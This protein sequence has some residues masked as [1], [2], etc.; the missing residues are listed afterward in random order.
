MVFFWY[1]KWICFL[2]FFFNI[3]FYSNGYTI[4]VWCVGMCIY[5]YKLAVNTLLVMAV[6]VVAVVSD[7]TP[8]RKTVELILCLLFISCHRSSSSSYLLS[9]ALAYHHRCCCCR[10]YC[11]CH[12]RNRHLIVTIIFIAIFAIVRFCW[13]LVL[14]LVAA[15]KELV[16]NSMDRCR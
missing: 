11:Y 4:I 12:R 14:F 7:I 3:Y 1:K 6:L 9:S 10:R 15:V 16:D 8:Q 13:R 2:F 5:L